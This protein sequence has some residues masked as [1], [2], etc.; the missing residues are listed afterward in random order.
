L[1][2]AV[3]L[4]AVAIAGTSDARA[5]TRPGYGGKVEATLLGAPATFDPVLATTHAELSVSELVFDT[6]YRTELPHGTVRPHLAA[7][8]PELDASGTIARIALRRGVRFHDGAQ[9][10]P[11]D[12]A[13]SLERARTAAA[14]ALAPIARVRADGDGHAVEL[15]LKTA[16]VDVATLL[17]FAPASITRAGKPPGPRPIGTG[18]FRVS[19]HDAA[20]QRLVLD[21]FEDHFAGRPY[22]DQL[23]LHW[24]DKPDA[25]PRRFELDQLQLSARGPST[26]V[27]G[28]PKYRAQSTDGPKALLVFVG[29]GKKQVR[30]TADRAFR[31]ALSLAIDR[32][33]LTSVNSGEE[34]GPAVEPVPLGSGGASLGHGTRDDLARARTALAEA[35]RRV[36]A[37][38][39]ANLPRLTLEISYEATR[40]DDRG[41]AERVARALGKLGI[42]AAISGVSA[43]ELR[44]RAVRGT[45]DLWIGQLAAPIQSGTAW[46]WWSLA[47]SV[48]GDDWAAKKL[49]AGELTSKA[50]QTEFAARLPIVPLMFRGLRVWHRT[51]IRGV[52]FDATGRLCYAELFVFGAPVKSRVGP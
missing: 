17:S 4:V 24:H 11:A 9:V 49:A 21:A 34:V 29:F 15:E 44:Q 35:G 50:A 22:L 36:P 7:E 8:L 3:L 32:D 25:E 16:G 18:P 5:E 30:V 12:V 2:L 46:P 48:G 39:P 42:G 20:K 27:G 10:T 28:Q 43:T 33:A 52:R 14:W 41:I 31:R 47:F 1:R 37:L 13:A 23:V 6:L 40:P 38:A 19:S 51:D 45:T 26:F